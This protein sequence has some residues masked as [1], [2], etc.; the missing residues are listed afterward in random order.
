MTPVE[1][2]ALAERMPYDRAPPL[3][4]DMSDALRA[5]AEEIERLRAHLRGIVSAC[6]ERDGY[7]NI[8][9][10]AMQALGDDKP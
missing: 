3:V 9:M 7:A 2:M 1:L 5:A 4:R 10:T 8:C 6:E